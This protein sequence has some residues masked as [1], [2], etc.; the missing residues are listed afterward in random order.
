MQ[1]LDLQFL[2]EDLFQMGTLYRNTMK[3]IPTKKGKGEVLIGDSK[4]GV[5]V[6]EWKKSNEVHVIMN[7]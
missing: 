3:L 6:F 5:S 2:R 1:P 7:F 4:G